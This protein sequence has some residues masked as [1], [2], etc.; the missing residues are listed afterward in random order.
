[1]FWEFFDFG[2]FL[3]YLGV[4]ISGGF[5]GSLLTLFHQRRQLEW[6]KKKWRDTYFYKREV[7]TLFKLVDTLTEWLS[8]ERGSDKYKLLTHQLNNCFVKANFYWYSNTDSDTETLYEFAT[9][10][11][12]IDEKGNKPESLTKEK[13]TKLGVEVVNILSKRLTPHT[14]N[15]T[16]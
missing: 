1:M 13:F 11:Q 7:L 6:E 14:E 12:V 9:L 10:I 4:L 2:K 15:L 3:P 8:C 5:L 16:R